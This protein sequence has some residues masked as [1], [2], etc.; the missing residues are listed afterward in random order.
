[1]ISMNEKY[2]VVIEKGETSYGTYV[3]DL[4]RCIAVAANKK[5]VERL[6]AEA[7]GLHIEAML[8]QGNPVPQPRV[9]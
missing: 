7:I 8:E 6:I 9:C 3:P 1:M 5:E 4:P 2:A